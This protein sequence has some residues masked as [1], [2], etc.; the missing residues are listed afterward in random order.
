[1]RRVLFHLLK[2]NPINLTLP[3][4]FYQNKRTEHQESS[5]QRIRLC[6]SVTYKNV[7]SN[8]L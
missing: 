1:M 3:L 2:F 4:K 8:G 7:F 5:L 6:I